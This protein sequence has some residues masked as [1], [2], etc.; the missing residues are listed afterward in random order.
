[1]Q[2]TIDR[3]HTAIGFFALAILVILWNIRVEEKQPKRDVAEMPVPEQEP[4]TD[5]SKVLN[6][7]ESATT[8]NIS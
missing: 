1:M 4:I 5:K 3:G 6:L 7:N 8:R 2:A